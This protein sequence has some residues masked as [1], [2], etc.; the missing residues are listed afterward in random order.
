MWV[1]LSLLLVHNLP[2]KDV[3]FSLSLSLSLFLSLFL[4]FISKPP[5][6]NAVAK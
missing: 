1:F 3:P 4:S 5:Q 6:N 2:R